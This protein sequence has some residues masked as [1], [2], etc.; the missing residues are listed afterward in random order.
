MKSASAKPAADLHRNHLMGS[1]AATLQLLELYSHKRTIALSLNDFVNAYKRPKSSV[2][3]MLSTLVNTGFLTQDAT[4]K[5]Y[6]LT[7]KLWRLGVPALEEYD[8]QQLSAPFLR[9]LMQSTNETVHLAIPVDTGDVVY[10]RKYESARSIRVQTQ[11]GG[12]VPAY[13]T[14]TGRCI[15]AYNASFWAIFEGQ[16]LRALTPDTKTRHEAIELVLDEVREKG[17][18]VTRGESHPEMGGIAA[19]I[20]DYS[21]KVI[22]ACGCAIPLFRMTDELVQQVLPNVLKAAA[23]ISKSLEHG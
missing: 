16:P 11:L 8:L 22:A 12:S 5:L 23:D 6:K 9:S 15:L 19:P 13:C 17:Y 21:G 3:R 7:L 10:V 2:H 1:V 18:A 14:A 4:T 20:R